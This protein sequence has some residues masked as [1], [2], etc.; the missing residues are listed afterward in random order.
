MCVHS[1]FAKLLASTWKRSNPKRCFILKTFLF[2]FL[3]YYQIKSI[4]SR[5][6]RKFQQLFTLF[7]A[8]HHHLRRAQNLH[9][10]KKSPKRE[11]DSNFSH[12]LLIWCLIINFMASPPCLLRGGFLRGVS[13]PFV[14]TI[15]RALQYCHT[16]ANNKIQTTLRLHSANTEM[17]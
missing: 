5:T 16:V 12:R 17:C 8:C 14:A 3:F 2:L 9:H 13:R 11:T 10:G 6:R 7:T 15:A 1:P 4:D